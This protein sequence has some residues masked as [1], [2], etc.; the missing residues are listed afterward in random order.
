MTL[1]TDASRTGAPHVVRE[2]GRQP[3]SW[4]RALALAPDLRDLLVRPGQRVA[5]IGCGTSWF[6]AA[7]Y[8]ALRERAG[9]GETDAFTASELPAGR[10]YDALLAISRSGT[11]TE[12]VRALEATA[13]ETVAITAVPGLA[14]GQVADHEV[15]LDFA[16]ERSVVQT[17]FATTTLMLLR[18]AL[19][20]ELAPVVEQAEEV[21]G[22]GH[23]VAEAAATASQ[24][25]FLGQGWAEGLAREAALKMREAAQLWTESYVQMEYRHGPI[26]IAQPGR[27]AWVFGT[28]VP[29]L[30]E[31]LAATGAAVVDDPLDPVVDLVRAQLLAVRRAEELRL[32][33][34]HPRHL[35]RSVVL[36]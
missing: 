15:A 14:V 32:D 25:T 4:R 34:D 29:G 28:P 18:G 7:A 26:A 3:D 19:G 35:T 31:D 23:P 20:E 24:L 30:L 16:D 12:V 13:A 10:G 9:L 2:I 6:M 17:L 5:V 33:P 1:D 27:A 21:L 11:T 36:A 22:G 8:A